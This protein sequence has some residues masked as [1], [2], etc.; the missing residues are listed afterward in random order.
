MKI[1]TFTFLIFFSFSALAGDVFINLRNGYKVSESDKFITNDGQEY[2]ASYGHTWRVNISAGYKPDWCKAMSCKVG[3]SHE[4]S[5]LS[6]KPFND[7]YDYSVDQLF[8]EVEYTF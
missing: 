2:N 6:G 3:Y 4:S 8:F 7:E 1:I 5:P